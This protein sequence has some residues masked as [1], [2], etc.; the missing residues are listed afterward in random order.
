MGRAKR[1]L[2]YPSRTAAILA[3]REQGLTLQQAADKIGISLSST[4]GLVASAQR[5]SQKLTIRIPA[6]VATMIDTAAR[7]RGVRQDY[8]AVK[9]LAAVAADDLFDAVLD[10]TGEAD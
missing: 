1:T 10:D 7:K 8:L 3:L 2:G 6:N 4:A 5:N 9:L